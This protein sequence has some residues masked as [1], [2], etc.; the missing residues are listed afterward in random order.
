MTLRQTHAPFAPSAAARRA[1]I[2]AAL[3]QA[4]S[5]E[6]LR[7]LA[8]AAGPALADDLCSIATV[9]DSLGVSDVTLAGAAADD[10]EAL[11]RLLRIVYS[12]RLI[13][14]SAGVLSSERDERAHVPVPAEHSVPRGPAHA[15][16]QET[17]ESLASAFAVL[18]RTGAK[19][20]RAPRGVLDALRG[21]PA[22]SGAV[23][24]SLAAAF[25]VDPEVLVPALCGA[26]YFIEPAS[27]WMALGAASAGGAPCA[28]D[29]LAAAVATLP[30]ATRDAA[31]AALAAVDAA[32][33]GADAQG[34]IAAALASLETAMQ[35]YAQH[36]GVS[37]ADD[38][39]QALLL[40]AGVADRVWASATDAPPVGQRA[41]DL[42]EALTRARVADDLILVPDDGADPLPD[43]SLE[44]AGGRSAPIAWEALSA[45]LD[46]GAGISEAAP[47][48]AVRVVITNT[49][50]QAISAYLLD[51]VRS[52]QPSPPSGGGYVWPQ[53]ETPAALVA[54]PMTF[55]ASR[56]NAYVKCPRR[57]FFE[58]LCEAL[59]DPSSLHASYGRVVHDAL[60]ALHRRIRV[61]SEHSAPFML[62]CLLRELDVAFGKARADFDSQLEYEVSR[63]RAR[64]MAEHY[65]RW[66]AAEAS[67]APMEIVHVELLQRQRFGGHDFIGYIDRV[68]RPLGGGPVT[69]FD[70]KTGRIDTDAREYLA[71]VRR[72]DEAQLALYYAMRRAGGDEI[73]RIALVSIRDPRDAAWVLALDITD[74][75]GKPPPSREP[76]DGVLRAT[77]SP[78]DLE[79]SLA[80]LIE[81]CDLLTTQGLGHFPAGEDP[82]C[83]F[84]AYARACRERPAD[85]E[86]IF[87]R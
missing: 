64:R 73:A 19:R 44:F 32:R 74:A 41:R 5:D 24:R 80:T 46:I 17:V 11:S 51:D 31:L 79:A 65:V 55:S 25:A 1:A 54:P 2:G 18:S 3:W 42:L 69:I 26:P 77:C 7:R 12:A 34:S 68:D 39:F 9:V 82:P 52:A 37:F 53:A 63:T 50:A 16:A 48:P 76:H 59:E 71:K 61:P 36:A 81:R 23:G 70:Y 45:A 27:L 67:R 86:R 62:D 13:L 57:W 14:R 8:G 85:G 43:A 47:P 30:A 83:N 6:P 22:A 66:L 84:C 38:E 28:R 21:R 78:A 35:G 87:A 33:A 29:A 56:L 72:G 4:R 40:A 15:Q 10:S 49:Q 20:V 75:A 58:Y 60:E